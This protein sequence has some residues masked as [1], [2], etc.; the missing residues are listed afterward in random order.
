MVLDDLWWWSLMIFDTVIFLGLRDG[1][2]RVLYP[3]RK[4]VTK[5]NDGLVVAS[6]RRNRPSN[7]SCFFLWSILKSVPFSS[8]FRL[9]ISGFFMLYQ[10]FRPRI[11]SSAV[12][13]SL[14]S[15]GPGQSLPNF[16]PGDL[17]ETWSWDD[18]GHRLVIEMIEWFE[19][20][21]N[22]SFFAL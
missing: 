10:T 3:S 15:S 22:A 8:I 20:I 4:M 9:S 13:H 18:L 5:K 7:C 2:C 6:A 14:T 12:H 19:N 11:I 21:W 16:C 17:A 1:D